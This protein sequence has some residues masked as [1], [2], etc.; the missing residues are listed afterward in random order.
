M[1]PVYRPGRIGCSI[2]SLHPS[3]E[4]RCQSPV[5]CLSRGSHLYRR[6][7]V[8]SLIHP[9]TTPIYTTTSAQKG[10]FFGAAA[11]QGIAILFPDTSPR[12][13][14]VPGEGDAWDFGI[15]AGFYLDATKPE[16][17]KHYNMY[18]HVTSE[19]PEVIKAAGLP[20]VCHF[21]VFRSMPGSK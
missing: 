18:T 3:A 11:A 4:E 6:Q 20:I 7:R 21:A 9:R 19:L 14:G 5:A 17:S 8:G 10:G 13:A 15:A 1:N 12:G 2:Q 16:Y